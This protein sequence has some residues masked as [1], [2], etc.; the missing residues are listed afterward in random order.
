MVTLN[1]NQKTD[2]MF[3]IYTK[4]GQALGQVERSQ[5]LFDGFLS[6]W[7]NLDVKKLLLSIKKQ[8]QNND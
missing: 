8:S 1:Y 5:E 7:V 4:D 2:N 6:L 3:R